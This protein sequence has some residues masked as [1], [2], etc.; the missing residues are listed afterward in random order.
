[1][2]L[3]WAKGIVAKVIHKEIVPVYGGK[4]LSRKAVHSRVGNISLRQQSTTAMLRVSTA[5]W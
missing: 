3:F 2:S 1:V 5:H 4:C